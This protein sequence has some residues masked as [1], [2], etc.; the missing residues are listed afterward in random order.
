ML[1]SHRSQ[2][3]FRLRPKLIS[4]HTFGRLT[5]SS[6]CFALALCAPA[7]TVSAQTT[8]APAAA[9]AAAPP[10]APPTQQ[11]GRLIVREKQGLAIRVLIDGID[12]GAAPLT[13]DL[14]LGSYEVSGLASTL[15][16]TPK[17]VTLN[18]NASTEVLIEAVPAM[19]RMEVRTSDGLGTIL[20]DGRPV[21]Q[22]S[23]DGDLPVGEHVLTVERDGFE[24]YT[25]TL[26]LSHGQVVVESVT[27]QRQVDS[28]VEAGGSSHRVRDGVYGGV[29]L[30]LAFMPSGS[31]N[32]IETACST[33]GAT[34]C[35]PSNPWGAI[36]QGYVG[37]ALEP[38]GFEL[39]VGVLG[40]KATPQAYFDGEH[41]SSINPLVAQPARD[42]K[43]EIYRAGILS[44]VRVRG[45]LELD[46]LR[47]Y[48]AM[49]AGFSWKKMGL[50]RTVTTTDGTDA[51][52]EFA[53]DAVSYISPGVTLDVG[54]YLPIGETTGLTVG[55]WFWAETAGNKAR[56]E[57]ALNRVIVSDGAPPRP[58]ATPQ[59]DLA[60]GDQ[61]YIG[62]YVGIQFGP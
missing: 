34:S 15:V 33:I 42:E 58:L 54:A 9:P 56:T 35:E 18:P 43:F 32:T 13:I 55:A 60:N 62:P 30:G 49:G 36:I 29:Q 37:Y 16:A 14:P 26:R 12:R 8:D 51:K 21:G 27:L 41:G 5:T 61:I 31:D 45:S 7:G 2:E 57:P 20:L 6:L 50:L 11:T 19:A 24:P 44:A 10:A 48:G 1:A 46:W 25:K 40:D 17:Q 39:L 23:F 28:S 59:Y 22:G 47:L 4:H 53:P 3:R 52:N 38:L